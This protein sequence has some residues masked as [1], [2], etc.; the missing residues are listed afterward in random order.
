[1]P[2]LSTT[3][4]VQLVPP[5]PSSVHTPE[6]STTHPVQLA[7]HTRAQYNAHCTAH[8]LVPEL[9]TTHPVLLIPPYPSSVPGT[10]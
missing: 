8:T 9:S 2:E 7:P 6:L 3:H 10:P 5:H 4:P 1:M